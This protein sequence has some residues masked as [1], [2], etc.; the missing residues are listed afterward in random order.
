MLDQGPSPAQPGLRIVAGNID[1]TQ[2][3]GLGW[4]RFGLGLRQRI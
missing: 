2:P 1:L 4:V 3:V